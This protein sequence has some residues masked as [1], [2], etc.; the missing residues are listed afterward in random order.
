MDHFQRIWLLEYSS[1]LF[2]SD[3]SLE[4][5]LCP[6]KQPAFLKAQG[7]VG[8]TARTAYT[9]FLP[10][11]TLHRGTVHTAIAVLTLM[12][13]TVEAFV[14]WAACSP[15]CYVMWPRIRSVG[16]T[17]PECNWAL[18][19]QTE[20]VWGKA[21]PLTHSIFH[22]ANKERRARMG[23]AEP[24]VCWEDNRPQFQSGKRGKRDHSMCPSRKER[25]RY[26]NMNRAHVNMR[27]WE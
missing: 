8:H 20:E 24:E 16:F 1:S 3:S 27:L 15:F 12:A 4:P 11:V 19:V 5:Q 26:R 7:C 18:T 17:V 23:S 10:T 13:Q 14:A 22:K 25:C 6:E 21:S 2:L 9:W